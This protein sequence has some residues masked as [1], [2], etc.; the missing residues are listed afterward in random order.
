MRIGVPKEIKQAE[1]RVGM[2]PGSVREA[3]AHGH[4]VVVETNAG[5]GIGADDAA[6]A[7]AGA[8]IAARR[9]TVFEQADLI[10]KVKEPQA[11][12]RRH[13]ARRPDP[14]HLPAPGRRTPSRP[15]D[16]HR[17]RRG[18]HR[19]RDR[20]RRPTAACRCWRR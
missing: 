7:A 8:T 2:T 15:R 16:L 13:A 20:H 1:Q 11:A 18:V 17:Q 12:E 6:Y 5:V 3:V 9:R 14:V 19:L 10:V 4:Q